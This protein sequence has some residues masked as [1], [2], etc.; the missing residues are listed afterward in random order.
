[1]CA[2]SF[3]VLQDLLPRSPSY[4][5]D[6]PSPAQRRRCSEHDDELRRAAGSGFLGAIQ[7]PPAAHMHLACKPQRACCLQA[8]SPHRSA[9]RGRSELESRVS[10]SVP[11]ECARFDGCFGAHDWL[12]P[13]RDW[14]QLESGW[15]RLVRV[16]RLAPMSS[17][18]CEVKCERQE[19]PAQ[20]HRSECVVNT[21][22]PGNTTGT[23]RRNMCEG[24][25]APGASRPAAA[26]APAPDDVEAAA[27]HA[28]RRNIT[29]IDWRT[30]SRGPSLQTRPRHQTNYAVTRV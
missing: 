14:R 13:V 24:G 22:Q 28:G 27:Q 23:A 3:T 19:R 29:L 17:W 12:I 25:V 11:S 20:P 16:V 2:Q 1:M 5:P 4:E 9:G 15:T 10:P 21:Q 8:A 7:L 30:E 6:P 18:C 26:T